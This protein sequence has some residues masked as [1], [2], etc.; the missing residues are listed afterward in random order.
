[1]INWINNINELVDKDGNKIGG[2]D[3][4]ISKDDAIMTTNSTTDDFVRTSRQG[5]NRYLY[6]SFYGEDKN[7]EEGLEIPDEDKKKFKVNPNKKKKNDKLKETSREKMSSV[8]E[9]IFTK[10][11][12]DRDIVDKIKNGEIRKNGIPPLDTIRDSNPILI[13]KVSV[14]KDNIEKNNASGEEKAVIL[15]YLL[16]I[17]LVDIPREYK[18]ELKKKLK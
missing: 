6:R 2:S 16:D 13:R 18:E 7:G 10:K 3:G 17:N 11:D 15:N 1:M 8:L 9:D 14:L 12:F 5:M 4:G